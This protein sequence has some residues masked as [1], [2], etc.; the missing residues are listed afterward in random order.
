MWGSGCRLTP[1]NLHVGLHPEPHTHLSL[2]PGS[3]P[4]GLRPPLTLN[5]RLW[6]PCLLNASPYPLNPKTPFLLNDSPY[7]L[8]PKTPCLLN[9]SPYP[10]N[11]EGPPPCPLTTCTAPDQPSTLDL[12]YYTT[13]TRPQTRPPLPSPHP[14]RFEQKAVAVLLTLLSLGVKNI[15]L[16]PKLPAF[17]TSDAVQVR[18]TPA[19]LAARLLL[20]LLLVL[21]LGGIALH[22][23]MAART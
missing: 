22:M 14:D 20:L 9:A 4:S 18:T 15:R 13:C 23:M 2:D 6:N 3:P 1:Y 8:N 17:L 11:L 10:L 21:Q 12:M 7:P 16:G 19:G 5:T